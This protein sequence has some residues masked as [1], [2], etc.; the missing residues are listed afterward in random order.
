MRTGLHR[1]A[2]RGPSGRDGHNCAVFDAGKSFAK[3]SIVSPAGEILAER[4][5]ATPTRPGPGYRALDTDA[6]FGWL[7]VQLKELSDFGI[8]RIMPVAHGATC[9][10]LDDTQNLVV[11]VQDYESDLPPAIMDAYAAA[12]PAFCETLSPALPKGLNLG[13]QI[14]WHSRRDPQTFARVRHIL[15]YAQYWSWRL[16]GEMASEVTSL[17]CHSDL[18]APTA[19]TFSSLVR[20]EDWADRFAPLRSAWEVA[21]ALRPQIARATGLADT[22]TV[23]VGVHDSNA[24]LAALLNDWKPGT[25]PPAL[26]STGTWFVA[27]APGGSLGALQ[28]ERDCMAAVDVF[29]RAVPCARFMGGRAFETITGGSFDADIDADTVRSVM[30]DAA[31]A[32]PSFLDAGGPYPNHRGEIRGLRTDTVQTRTALGLLYLALVSTTCL[33]MI[34]AGRTLLI[35]GAAARNPLLCGLIAAL[36]DGPVFH[37]ASASAVTLG[38]AALAYRDTANLAPRFSHRRAR[39]VLA[40][41]LRAY[42]SLWSAAVEDAVAA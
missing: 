30:R 8:D 41:D 9:A 2:L 4:R 26:L 16:S 42:R 40:Q 25:A 10:F 6:I 15:P 24:A 11:P 33:D 1:V 13:A 22:T 23:C 19:G 29:G 35:E 5:L 34:Q 37:N 27:M 21:G 3:L 32:L 39:P 28:P 17:G 18:W 20:T 31:F 14:Y 7:L 38:G 36:H 12:R